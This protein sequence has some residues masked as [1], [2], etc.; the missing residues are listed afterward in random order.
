MDHILGRKIGMTQIF[1]EDGS[2]APV[3][4]IQA[5]P[6][7]VTAAAHR[8]KGWLRCCTGRLS[9][10]QR[11]IESP[12]HGARLDKR[13]GAQLSSPHW[14][15]FKKRNLPAL[16]ILREFRES[17][18]GRGGRQ[19]RDRLDLRQGRVCGRDRH[20]QGQELPGRREAPRLCRRSQDARPVRPPSYTGLNWLRHHAGPGIQGHTHGRSHGPCAAHRS[21]PAGCG[22]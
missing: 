11:R 10:R 16:R 21:E 6:C 18:G 22:G 5:G 20:D 15:Y 13:P 3:T 2:V 12:M 17:A 4:V 19:T 8:R 14:G 1:L 7:F 9:S